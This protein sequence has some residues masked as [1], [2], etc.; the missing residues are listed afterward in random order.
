MFYSQSTYESLIYSLRDQYPEICTST[1]HLYTIGPT[2]TFVTG[3]LRFTQE[4]ELHVTEVI[5]F[6]AGRILNYGYEVYQKGHK[7]YWYDPQPHPNDPTLVSNHPHH[8]HIPP[9]IKHHRIPAP[10]LSFTSPN[11]PFLIQE[12]LSS[13]LKSN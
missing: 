6:Q 7:L 1:L 4:V 3:M 8:K 13:L 2:A 11:L 10:S 5:D 9:D 12:L